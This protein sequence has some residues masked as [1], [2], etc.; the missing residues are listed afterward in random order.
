MKQFKVKVSSQ[1]IGYATVSARDLASAQRKIERGD[2]HEV[3]WDDEG[4][5]RVDYIYWS[6]LQEVTS[7]GPSV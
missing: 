3:A 4:L 5:N 1:V 7:D 2:E 6:S